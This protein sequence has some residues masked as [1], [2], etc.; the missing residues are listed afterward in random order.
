MILDTIAASTRKRVD[1]QKE[2]K[3]LDAVKKE[4]L[5]CG[6]TPSLFEDALRRPGVSFICEVKKASPS[7]GLIAPHFPY[8]DIARE[9]EAAGADAISVLTEPEFFLGSNGYLKEIHQAVSTPLLRKDFTIDEYQIYEAKV[10]G[11][12]A[13]LL[14]CALLQK[15]QLTR[16]IAISRELGLTPLV[17]AHTDEEVAMAADAGA[18]VIGINN[19][20]LKTFEVDFSNALRLR[21]LVDKNTVFVA[22]SG[23]KGPEDMKALA[24]A[25]VDAVLIGEALMRAEDKKG[26]LR[27]LRE[28]A[29]GISERI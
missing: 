29:G 22:E 13:V 11:A 24:E 12:S 9:Y 23:I 2:K 4:A 5:R 1:A 17:E 10:I 8:V 20:N 16:Y 18:T 28:A 3:S 25:K 19:R 7:K 21:S 27:K 6:G 14:I 15:E 26:M